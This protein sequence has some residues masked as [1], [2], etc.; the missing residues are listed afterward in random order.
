MS[1]EKSR[2]AEETY[3]KT[4][5]AIEKSLGLAVRLAEALAAREAPA[6][7]RELRGE[8]MNCRC[9]VDLL[10]VRAIRF[11][12]DGLFRQPETD[13]ETFSLLVLEDLYAYA[14]VLRR[15]TGANPLF[16]EREVG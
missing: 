10:M 11:R 8:L 5:T 15:F 4:K 1:T 7:V 2:L 9:E 6:V 13:P 16:E 3:A 12:Q 14:R